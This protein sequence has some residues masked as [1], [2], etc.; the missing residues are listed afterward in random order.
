[1]SV[2]DTI[3]LLTSACAESSHWYRE[4]MCCDGLTLLKTTPLGLEKDLCPLKHVVANAWLELGLSNKKGNDNPQLQPCLSFSR[5]NHIFSL[6]LCLFSPRALCFTLSLK[7]SSLLTSP[8]CAAS[9]KLS[10]HSSLSPL[11]SQGA[12]CTFHLCLI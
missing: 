5:L 2:R 10:L 3:Q 11:P 6:I 7:Q 1:M 4:V 12:L 9:L 8:S